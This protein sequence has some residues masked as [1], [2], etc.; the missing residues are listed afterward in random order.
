MI[1]YTE[2]AIKECLSGILSVR[3]AEA[4]AA[5]SLGTTM[6]EVPLAE[7]AERVNSILAGLRSE[8]ND[9]MEQLATENLRQLLTNLGIVVIGDCVK[10]ELQVPPLRNAQVRMDTWKFTK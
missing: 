2:N 7:I 10:L 5:G 3:R 8:P 1:D 4:R 9:T 6:I